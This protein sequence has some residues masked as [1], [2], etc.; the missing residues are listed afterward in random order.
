M[1]RQKILKQL[2]ISF[3]I[4]AIFNEIAVF[5]HWYSIIWWFDM[6][7][8]FLG[9][10]SVFYLSAI[11]WLPARKWVPDRRFLFECVITA[12]LIGVLWESLELYLYLNYGD[13]N[14]VLIDSFSDLIFDFA[15]ALL[16]AYSMIPFLGVESVKS[17][18]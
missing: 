5:L 2:A 6:P 12:L 8:H 9:G 17:E 11:V 1:L 16:G 13:P 15:G 7:M 14:F 3:V 10:I 4:L 18:I